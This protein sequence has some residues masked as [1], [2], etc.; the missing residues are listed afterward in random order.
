MRPFLFALPL[1]AAALMPVS[2]T[3][4]AASVIVEGSSIGSVTLQAGT[5]YEAFG[6]SPIPHHFT[7]SSLT[8]IHNTLNSS[9]INTNGVVTFLL[10]ETSAGL[11]FMA[12]IDHETGSGLSLPDSLLGMHS[13]APSGSGYFINGLLDFISVHDNGTTIEAEGAFIWDSDYHGDAVAWAGLSEGD[14]GTFNFGSIKGLLST[15]N[16]LDKSDTFQFLTF[17]ENGWEVAALGSFVNGAFGFSFQVVPIPPAALVGAAGLVGVIVV[18][19]RR[20]LA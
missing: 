13:E 20:L 7:T 1:A 3:A 14:S 4:H 9:G 17:G 19:R 10:A 11:S 2:N 16:G 6:G 5:M 12:L 15:F 8:A 18:R